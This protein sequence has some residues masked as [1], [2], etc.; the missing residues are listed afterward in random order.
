[1]SS[2]ALPPLALCK[3]A[4]IT[5]GV[6]I[7]ACE[8]WLNLLLLRCVTKSSWKAAHSTVVAL[9]GFDQ[10]ANLA[11]EPRRASF[12][13]RTSRAKKPN[14]PLMKFKCPGETISL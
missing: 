6:R 12:Q 14:G 8:N 4:S 7:Y 13:H 10:N 5:R 3:A 2:T 11:L 1:M 9:R